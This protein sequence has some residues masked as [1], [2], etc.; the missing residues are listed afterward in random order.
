M[1]L[2]HNQQ[3]NQLNKAR[4]AHLKLSNKI[5]YSCG[6]FYKD[7]NIEVEYGLPTAALPASGSTGLIS[8]CMAPQKNDA[9]L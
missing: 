6:E 1:Y 2:L 4:K 8:A 5:N 3:I 9:K 7:Q